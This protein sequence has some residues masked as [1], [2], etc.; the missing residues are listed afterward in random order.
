MF[1]DPD[2]FDIA[3]DATHNPVFGIGLHFCLG[4]A[5]AR[6]EAQAA[7]EALLPELPLLERLDQEREYIDSFLI[8]GP[9]RIE[10]RRIAA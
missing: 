3:R 5:L 7:L 8:R 1:P 4:A 9:R 10:L 6:L 2:R